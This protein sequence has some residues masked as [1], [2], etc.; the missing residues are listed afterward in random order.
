MR[1]WGIQARVMFLALTP[2]VMIMLALVGYFTW[3]RI[4]EA[5]SSLS[6]RGSLLV[7]RLVPGVEFALFAGDA[8]A[9]QRLADTARGEADVYSV[10]IRDADGS[11][12]VHSGPR[13]SLPDGTATRLSREVLRTRL[14]TADFPE[15]ATSQDEP[16][17][18]GEV[19]VTMSRAATD[20]RQ[21]RLVVVAL[22]L[23]ALC[24]ALAIALALAIGRGVTRPVRRL[25]GAM[26]AL[27][28]GQRDVLLPA[29]GG[30]EF[31]TLSTG[32]NRM[33]ARLQAHAL[34]DGFQLSEC[35]AVGEACRFAG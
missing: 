35:L 10:T 34:D 25:A 15:Q 24:L 18:I 33:A 17:R 29:T 22:A 26:V 28:Q 1:R 16:T 6:E 27:E 32:F 11:E 2:S 23:G 9:M 20:A 12:L 7:Q 3:E 5:E 8:A 21:R 13:E 31:E 19:T 30:G 14:A 4:Q